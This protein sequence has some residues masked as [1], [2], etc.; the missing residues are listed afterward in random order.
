MRRQDS[1]DYLFE[2]PTCPICLLQLS[3]NINALPCGHCFHQDC[4]NRHLEKRN[5]CPNCRK[6]T[7]IKDI[8]PIFYEVVR[9]CKMRESINTLELR[10][11]VIRMRTL[12]ESY[13]EGTQYCY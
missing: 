5:A 1:K 3:S 13:E 9:N 4:I 2:L 6:Y 11:E 7:D 10:E 12:I 8:R